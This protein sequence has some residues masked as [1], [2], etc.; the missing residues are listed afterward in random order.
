MNQKC[1]KLQRNLSTF[2]SICN[3]SHILPLICSKT[4]N[5]VHEL[6]FY[7]IAKLQINSKK[8]NCKLSV[9]RHIPRKPSG[10]IQN[11]VNDSAYRLVRAQEENMVLKPWVLL[12]SLL[13]QDHHQGR[14]AGHK[15]GMQIEDLTAQAMWLRDISRQYGAF[16]HWPGTV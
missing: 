16:L 13:L 1:L 15:R 11:F 4:E 6:I 9:F 8:I 14:A 3:F 10:Q 2:R 5:V 12:A 7:C